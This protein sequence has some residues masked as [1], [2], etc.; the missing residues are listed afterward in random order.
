M[1]VL[2]PGYL[3]VL[4][5]ALVPGRVLRFNGDF[6][7]AALLVTI[8]TSVLL[9][10]LLLIESMPRSIVGGGVNGFEQMFAAMLWLTFPL[11]VWRGFVLL[12]RW[13]SQ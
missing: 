5:F 4:A 11:G 13:V 7:P 1:A 8:V 10:A 6:I 2:L 3:A 9:C 12:N